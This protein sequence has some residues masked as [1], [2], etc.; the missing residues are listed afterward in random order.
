MNKIIKCKQCDIQ[1]ASLTH[2]DI[3]YCVECYV[4]LGFLYVS[5]NNQLRDKLFISK[6]IV[7]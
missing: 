7:K 2:F 4:E 3:S 5:Y 6:N 1:K